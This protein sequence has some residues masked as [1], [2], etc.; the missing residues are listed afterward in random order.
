ME[1]T[2]AYESVWSVSYLHS[3]FECPTA[4]GHHMCVSST[5][6]YLLHNLD[7]L[8]K[9][10]AMFITHVSKIGRKFQWDGSWGNEPLC[11]CCS[12]KHETIKQCLH[13]IFI[14][15]TLWTLFSISVSEREKFFHLINFLICVLSK[16]PASILSLLSRGNVL[17]MNW[18][19]SPPY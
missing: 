18:K 9:T 19:Q 15:C 12:L 16:T 13:Q 4:I 1:R 14:V 11:S 2:S 8:M 17:H 7:I 6:I 5:W 10:L 3:L